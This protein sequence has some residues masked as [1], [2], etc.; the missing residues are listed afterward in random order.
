MPS[1]SLVVHD[2]SATYVGHFVQALHDIL[3]KNLDPAAGLYLCQSIDSAEHPQGLVFILGEQLDPFQR[4]PGCT[5]VYMNLSVVTRLG[6][7]FDASLRGLKVI[8]RKRNWLLS[9][10]ERS[11]VLLDFYAPQTDHLARQSDGPVFHFDYLVEPPKQ[12]LAMA[13]RPYDVC[14]V[15][16]VNTRRRAVLDAIA[17][18]GAV[19]SPNAGADIEDIAAQA[20][21]CLNIHAEKSNHLET[22]RI[23]AG[24]SRGTPVISETSYGLGDLAGPATFIQTGRDDALAGLVARALADPDALETESQKAFEWYGTHYWPAAQANWR[25]ICTDLMRLHETENLVRSA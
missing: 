23:L 21:L 12:R 8:R 9:K 15:G 24:L 13:D 5:Y 7:P 3:R 19:L 6:G 11:D 25:Q 16:G 22:P 2:F 1:T 4:R 14:F 18:T 17:A 10:W 20:R